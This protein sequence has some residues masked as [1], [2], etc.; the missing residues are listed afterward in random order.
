MLDILLDILLD[1]LLEILLYVLSH[2]LL[3]VPIHAL[4][5]LPLDQCLEI[6]STA[7][8]SIQPISQNQHTVDPPLA[9]RCQPPIP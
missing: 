2:I 8:L 3:N 4:T 6:Q 9:K 5:I 1:V 7:T